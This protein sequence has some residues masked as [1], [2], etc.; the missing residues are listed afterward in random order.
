MHVLIEGVRCFHEKHG[1][2]TQCEFPTNV[3]LDIV[4][5]GAQL[6]AMAH[7][8]EA[9]VGDEDKRYVR[10]HLTLE[11]T[12]E[13]LIALGHCDEV[14]SLDALADRLYVL[15]GDAVTY[16]L[17]LQE[18]FV[19]VHLSNM[20]K[21]RRSDDP[22]RLRDK[23]LNYRPPDL[24]SVLHAYRSLKRRT[25]PTALQQLH[26]ATKHCLDLRD[27]TPEDEAK[28]KVYAA[29]LKAAHEAQQQ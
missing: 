22:G 14:A 16:D 27:L 26:A 19:E 12:G 2:S 7:E 17:P 20:T 1:I 23:G 21:Q 28:V 13:W 25:L 10:A 3:N 24:K 4:G 15:F 9:R 11:E 8:L 29:Q 6:C 18:A 5:L